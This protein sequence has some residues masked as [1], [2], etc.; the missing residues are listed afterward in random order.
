MPQGWRYARCLALWL[1]LGC[2]PLGLLV[3]SFM[4]TEDKESSPSRKELIAEIQRR[5]AYLMASDDSSL[6]EKEVLARRF[7]QALEG[8]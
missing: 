2:S 8:E 6:D 1:L 4:N 7:L 5:V 3:A